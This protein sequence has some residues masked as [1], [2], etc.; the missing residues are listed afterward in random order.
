MVLV[1]SELQSKEPVHEQS[2]ICT[3]YTN[4]IRG[5]THFHCVS[6]GGGGHLTKPPQLLRTEDN[7]RPV[8]MLQAMQTQEN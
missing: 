2:I 5:D 7:P 8:G 3:Q 4:A 6:G 1:V